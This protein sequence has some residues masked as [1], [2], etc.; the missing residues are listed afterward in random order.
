MTIDPRHLQRARERS[1]GLGRADG[2]EELDQLHQAEHGLNM[3][4]EYQAG[5]LECE[6][7]DRAVAELRQPQ[8][9]HEDQ[10]LVSDRYPVGYATR[11]SLTEIRHLARIA[12]RRAT[13]KVA[14][15]AWLE[16]LAARLEERA[17]EAAR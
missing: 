17:S 11:L 16:E 10:P 14:E 4:G 13:E 12:A 7:I 15:A 2:I 9:V 1:M 6:L 5:E 3:A 8:I